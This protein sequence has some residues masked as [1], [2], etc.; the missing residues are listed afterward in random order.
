MLIGCYPLPPPDLT[1]HETSSSALS[2]T[3]YALARAPHIQAKLRTELRALAL[4]ADPSAAA[5]QSVLGLPYLDACVR[6]SLRLHS[7][8]T[9]TMRVAARAGAVP[10]SAPFRD[11]RGRLCDCIRLARGDIV[12]VPM[13]AVNKAG[14]LWGADAHE[15]RPERWLDADGMSEEG[16]NA[17]RGLWG[18]ILTFG[19]G[20]VVNGNRSCIGFRFALNE[21]VFISFLHTYGHST[22]HPLILH[23]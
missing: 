17:V 16:R 15:F 12:T 19:S 21:Y 7:P 10:V 6:E 22:H 3:L 5:L 1:G 9:S 20:S 23:A 13:Q 11:R 4:P 18:G 14:G 8:V 2:W